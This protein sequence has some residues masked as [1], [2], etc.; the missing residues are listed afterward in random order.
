MRTTMHP[1]ALKE[2]NALKITEEI[3]D[4]AKQ[5]AQDV[6]T[7]RTARANWEAK[8]DRLRNLRFGYRNKK[9]F[10][11][12]NCANYSIPLIDSHIYSIKPPYA[13]LAYGVTPICTFEPFGAEDIEPAKKKEVLFDW[14]MRTKVKFFKDYCIGIDKMLEQAIVIFK[15]VWEYTTRSYTDYL[16]L[17]DL[18]EEI[19]KAIYDERTTDDILE[20]IIIEELG[21]EDEFEEN[22]EEVRKAINKFREGEKKFEFT[23]LEV[24]NNRPLV[25]ARDLREDMVIPTDTTDLQYARFIQDNVWK[26]VNEIK[27]EMRDEKYE[28]YPE[29]TIEKWGATKEKVPSKYQDELILLHEV[30][31][32]YDINDDGIKERCIL[33]YPE[34]A[35]QDVLRFIEVPYDHG[36]FPYDDVRRE[37]I[38]EGIYKARGICE[39]DEDYQIGITQAINQAEDNGTIV[40]RPTIVTKRNTVTN[41]K[42]RSYVPG[43][44]VETIGSPDDYQIRQMTNLSQP[45]LFQ[46]A[47]YLKAW[48]DQRLG[49]ITAASSDPTNL[50]GMAQGGK[51]T[52][53]EINMLEG[54]QGKV[55]ALDLQIF[56]QQMAKVYGKIDALYDQ[57]GD[58]EEEVLTTGE[59]PQKITRREIQ[60]KRDIIPNGRLD[61]TNPQMRAQKAFNLIKMFTGDPD[62]KQYELKQLFLQDYDHRIS[63]KILYTQE[64]KAQM[65]EQKNTML[66]QMRNKAINE[67]ID[68][69]QIDIMLEVYKE[70]LLVP[71]QGRKYAPDKAMP[72]GKPKP[73]IEERRP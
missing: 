53:R 32:W 51:K 10:P 4:F 57:Y 17:D 36:E 28:E 26:T 20:K 2:V 43:E 39:L 6:E 3:K 73:P 24:E 27:K 60:G 71:I 69:K 63:K 42:N 16:D 66:Q 13:N 52:A 59:P 23:L 48:A 56:Q 37:L 70:Q 67:G 7:E 54:L 40:N 9:V 8:I 46:F 64:E 19:L 68:L 62:I 41:I 44:T 11:W 61:N 33:T 14:R 15:T 38:D 47:Q 72:S 22:I 50:P 45:A 12:K 30:C 29:E 5:T 49:N 18:D 55:Q 31:V 25:V 58:E 21:I 1:E 35:P 34:S 65:E